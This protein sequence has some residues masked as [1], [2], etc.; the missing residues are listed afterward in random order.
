LADFFFADFL[1]GGFVADFVRAGFLS[2]GFLAAD[3][4][5]LPPA[6]FPPP[7]TFSQPSA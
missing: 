2:E 7:N 4:R 1:A 3:V 5:V 6:P